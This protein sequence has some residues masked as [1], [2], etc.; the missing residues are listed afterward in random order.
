MSQFVTSNK[1]GG[2]RYMPFAFTELGV[3]MLSSVLYSD[4]VIEVNMNIM[5]VFVAMRQLII[6][7]Y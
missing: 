3:A 7:A 6:F 1:R 5:R 4:I 2:I